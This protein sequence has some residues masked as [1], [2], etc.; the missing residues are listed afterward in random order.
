MDSINLGL[1]IKG[2][3]ET[4]ETTSKKSSPYLGQFKYQKKPGVYVNL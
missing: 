3:E 1:E 4:V 2:V